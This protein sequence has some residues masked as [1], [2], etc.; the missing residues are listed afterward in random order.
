VNRTPRS[1]VSA[2]LTEE[3]QTRLAAL[4]RALCGEPVHTL[5]LSGSGREGWYLSGQRDG[6]FALPDTKGCHTWHE[7]LDA[8]EKWAFADREN[9]EGNRKL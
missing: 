3:C 2:M 8:A 4:S 9:T 6:D 5:W 1:P 7:A